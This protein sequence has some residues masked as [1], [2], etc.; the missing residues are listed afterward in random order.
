MTLLFF[1]YQLT[2]LYFQVTRK[3]QDKGNNIAN[4]W[5]DT[6]EDLEILASQEVLHRVLAEGP[7][8]S[9]KLPEDTNSKKSLSELEMPMHEWTEYKA[10]EELEKKDNKSANNNNLGGLIMPSIPPDSV[11]PL[12][13]ERLHE[14]ISNS[15]LFKG[16]GRNSSKMYAADENGPKLNGPKL[17]STRDQ[18]PFKS[19]AS[20]KEAMEAQWPE[21]MLIHQHDVYYNRD[22]KRENYEEECNNLRQRLIRREFAS[23]CTVFNNKDIF[24]TIGN[25]KKLENKTRSD[26]INVKVRNVKAIP[27][28]SN[29][30]R[31]SCSSR[32]QRI[33][34][35]RSPRKKS[36][37]DL[38]KP[39]DLLA[40][41]KR[42]QPKKEEKPP[43]ATRRQQAPAAE[44]S[45]VHRQ[46]SCLGC[47][48]LS[49]G[50][51]LIYGHLS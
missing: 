18:Y 7:S 3:L 49:E 44:L 28:D 50:K 15:E 48:P 51:Y 17:H 36:S 37:A 11:I 25:K 42:G 43:L 27:D 31:S 38:C 26:K 22:Q 24:V 10:L 2:F 8:S 6:K 29:S 35:R 1:D 32:Q 41:T 13:A 23:T 19:N 45:D 4:L 21:A 33:M 30:I 16:K 9:F 14:I 39:S 5:E 34:L 20:L 47:L 46:V 40:P 12:N